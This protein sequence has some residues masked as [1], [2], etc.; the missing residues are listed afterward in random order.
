MSVSTTINGR[1]NNLNALIEAC[2]PDRLLIESDT[3]SID[4]CT[5]RCL[6]ILYIVAHVKGWPI[7]DHWMDEV[8]EAERGA[9]RRLEANWKTFISGGNRGRSQRV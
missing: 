5:E 1:S 9:V 8:E 4:K 2:A 7:E 6:E 3:D